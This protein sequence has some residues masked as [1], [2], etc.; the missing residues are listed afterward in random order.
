MKKLYFGYFTA[1]LALASQPAAAAA[2]DLCLTRD[3]MRAGLSYIAPLVI[4][5]FVKFCTPHLTGDAALLVKGPEMASNYRAV[6]TSSPRDLELL[7]E[8]MNGLFGKQPAD[9]SLANLPVRLEENMAKD[10]GAKECV[11]AEKVVTDLAELPA[12]NILGLFETMIVLF[13]ES[14]R[15]RLANLS[16][17]PVAK[18]IFCG[19]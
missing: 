15:N 2:Q 7:L 4:G 16:G 14:K 6:A 5:G 18:S 10:I 19:N 12:K 3:E 11:V 9:L 13:E 8:K 1:L 17:K